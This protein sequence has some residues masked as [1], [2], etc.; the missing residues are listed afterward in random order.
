VVLLALDPTASLDDGAILL[1]A[2]GAV[3]VGPSQPAAR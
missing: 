3:I 2:E 1:P